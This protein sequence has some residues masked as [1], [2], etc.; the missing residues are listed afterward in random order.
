MYSKR[1]AEAMIKWFENTTLAP[2]VIFQH[3]GVSK[4]EQKRI[5]EMCLQAREDA[6]ER[7]EKWD[8]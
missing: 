1:V 5:L 4:S 7:W 2:K 3:F 6:Y 8:E